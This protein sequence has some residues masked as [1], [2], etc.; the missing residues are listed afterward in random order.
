MD[1]EGCRKPSLWR[2]VVDI[3]D[4]A[5]TPLDYDEPTVVLN[6]PGIVVIFK[7]AGWETD[8]YDV[9]KYGVPLTQAARYYLLSTF[10]GKTF[11]EDEFPLCH[12][13]EHGF[14][15]VHRLD[16]MSSGLIATTTN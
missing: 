15:F 14:G 9:E 16:Q 8:V 5:S 6:I 2:N 3:A 10:L 4:R 1:L 7:P 12:S 13:V 11:P